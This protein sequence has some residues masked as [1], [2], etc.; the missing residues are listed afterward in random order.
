MIYAILRNF[1]PAVILAIPSLVAAESSKEI[2]RRNAP[3]QSVLRRKTCV[4]ASNQFGIFRADLK[5][6]KWIKFDLPDTMPTGGKFGDVPEK[7]K[8]LL[9]VVSDP[10][11]RS[12]DN[13]IFGIYVSH[14][15][16]GT[17]GLLSKHHDY[18]SVLMLADGALFAVTNPGGH[19]TSSSLKVSKDMGHTWRDISGKQL[20]TSF[21]MITGIFPDPDHRGLVCLNVNTGRRN[22]FQADDKRYL[23][24]SFFYADWERTHPRDFF[25]RRNSNGM[26]IR[27]TLNNYFQYDFGDRTI[28]A[29]MDLSPDNPRITVRQGGAVVVPFTLRFREDMAGRNWYWKD[30]R[31]KG[32]QA[33]KPVPTN[34]KLLDNASNY[35]LWTVHV[36]F[37]GMRTVTRHKVSDL[38]RQAR[39][40][41]TVRKNILSDTAWKEV[42]L[43][44]SK[45]YH[46]KFDLGRLYDFKRPGT[47]KVQLNYYPGRLA[48]RR[49]GHWTGS[50][51]S[52]VF[53]VVVTGDE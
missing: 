19:T 42:Q 10:R 53:E 16:G 44:Q 14:D 35:G 48:D 25:D 7:S 1:V 49:G 3:L 8:L 11:G 2:Q 47:Y 36:D 52:R 9:Y 12:S 24:R 43:S 17:W 30:R 29:G 23:W 46:R 22:I 41:D 26:W 15:D 39:D 18:G 27:A 40:R 28:V 32:L 13:R 33:R 45:P 38:L 4:F 6:R 20:R 50:F 31:A 51:S 5:T 37:K 21:G 34:V